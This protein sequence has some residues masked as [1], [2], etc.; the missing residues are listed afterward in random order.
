MTAN[1]VSPAMTR[2][3]PTT[4]ACNPAAACSANVDFPIAGGPVNNTS[5]GGFGTGP[6]SQTE[7]SSD[8][9]EPLPGISRAFEMHHGEMGQLRVVGNGRVSVPVFRVLEPQE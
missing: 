4:E 2:S 5:I 1:G 9:R 3:H 7:T 8:R 6:S